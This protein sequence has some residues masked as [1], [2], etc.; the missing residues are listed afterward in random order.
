MQVVSSVKLRY[1]RFL[2]DA[3]MNIHMTIASTLGILLRLPLEILFAIAAAPSFENDEEAAVFS[4]SAIHLPVHEPHDKFL[5]SR[6]NTNSYIDLAK[7]SLSS[8]RWQQLAT[9]AKERRQSEGCGASTCMTLDSTPRFANTWQYNMHLH[10][11]TKIH[12]EGR[13]VTQ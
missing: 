7:I 8:P 9:V 5:A 6:N 13:V 12:V 4:T 10:V 11:E 3:I 2:L 1:D